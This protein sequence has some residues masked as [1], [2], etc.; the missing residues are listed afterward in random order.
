MVLGGRPWI[1]SDAMTVLLSGCVAQERLE[2]VERARPAPVVV[3]AA[4]R[5]GERAMH[6]GELGLAGQRA[7]CDAHRRFVAAR[8]AVVVTGMMGPG[9]DQPLGPLHLQIDTRR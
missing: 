2:L 9:E 4:R 6:Q 3:V 5:V 7:Q 1:L 8:A